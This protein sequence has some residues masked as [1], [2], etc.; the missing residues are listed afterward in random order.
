MRTWPPP[1]CRRA[2]DIGNFVTVTIHDNRRQ[3]VLRTAASTVGAVLSEAGIALYA[4]DTVEPPPG[5]WLAQD[6]HIFVR[7]ALPYVIRVDGREI[8]TRSYKTN[9]LDVLAEAGIGLVGRDFTR[10]GPEAA[11]A[12]DAVIEVVRVTEDFRIVDTPIPFETLWQPTDQFE[13][14]QR[15]LLQAGAPGVLR[16]RLRVTYENG[17][18]VSDS[19]DGEWVAQAPVSAIMGFGTRV[20]LRTVDTAA[21]PRE[22][23][24]VVRMRVT[25]YT[26]SS[27]GKPP[28]HPRYGITRSGLP[29]GTG[30]VAV[31]PSV[32][33]WLSDVFVPGYGIGLAGDTGG[34]VK[35]RWIDLGYDEDAYV[36]WSGYVDV[37]YLTPVPEAIN[38]LL[39]TNLP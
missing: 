28:D 1:H 23:Y 19:P 34:G 12:P 30:I 5:S 21:G 11:L 33:P 27:S 2:L 4:A 31:D 39:P 26:A 16:Q 25:A 36:G 7:R 22:Y 10:P 15:G 13:L 29:A 8:L 9:V 18:P 24:R 17:V 32:V 3:Q 20:V 6:L 35:G 37:Y 38:Y 14:D